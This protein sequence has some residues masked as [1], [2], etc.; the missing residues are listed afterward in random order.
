MKELHEQ[1]DEQAEESEEEELPAEEQNWADAVRQAEQKAQKAQEHLEALRKKAE[2]ATEDHWFAVATEAKAMAEAEQA[3][4]SIRLMDPLAQE[5]LAD[6]V[7]Y[8]HMLRKE[9]P[10][11]W[12][13]RTAAEAAVAAGMVAL[14]GC[15][16]NG[17]TAR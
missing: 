10:Q 7:A 8:E 2:Q 14:Q 12:V 6:L 1:Q 16:R 3:T 15:C 9:A 11:H 17:C 4:E 5:M 13:L